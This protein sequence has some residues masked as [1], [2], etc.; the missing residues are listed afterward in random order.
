[1]TILTAAKAKLCFDLNLK[2]GSE[3]LKHKI[4]QKMKY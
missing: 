3:D 1:M 4:Y 2:T